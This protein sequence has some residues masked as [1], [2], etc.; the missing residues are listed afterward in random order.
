MTKVETP[1]IYIHFE[2]WF[3]LSLSAN[4]IVY[5]EN[6]LPFGQGKLNQNWF[7]QG[8]NPGPRGDE[9]EDHWTSK[10]MQQTPSNLYMDFSATPVSM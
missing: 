5:L 10:P 3:F 7:T 4:L 9:D 2:M 1:K 8:Y 6:F